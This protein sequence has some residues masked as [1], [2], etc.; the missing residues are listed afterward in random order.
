[1]ADQV[2]RQ[3][4]VSLPV[5][6]SGGLPNRGVK[7][8][9]LLQQFAIEQALH[10]SETL[11][12]FTLDLSKAFN[13]IPR[14]PLQWLFRA[15]G[16]PSEATRFWFFNLGHLVR[17]PQC[18]GTL[19]PQIASRTGIPE[20]DAMSV[21]GM[22][23]LSSAYHYRI[24]SPVLQPFSYADNWSWITREQKAMMLTLQKVLNFALPQP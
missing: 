1:M 20:G 6:I 24:Q 16:I 22:V 14:R 8:L 4:A 10:N 5:H 7:D 12:G 17:L 23:I 13:R 21:L 19:G 2:L 9:S 15:F 3:L 11:G 18:M